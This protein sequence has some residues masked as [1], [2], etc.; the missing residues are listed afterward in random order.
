MKINP[1]GTLGLLILFAQ[2]VTSKAD[3]QWSLVQWTNQGLEQVRVQVDSA[4]DPKWSDVKVDR[5]PIDPSQPQGQVHKVVL[6]GDTGC[7]LKESLQGGSYQDCADLKKWPFR[8]VADQIAAEKPNLVVHLGDYHYREKCSKGELCQKLGAMTGYGFVPWRLDFWEPIAGIL[9]KKT[10]WIIVRGNHE[11]CERAHEGY[12]RFF[13]SGQRTAGQACVETEETQFLRWGTLLVVN[14]DSSAVSDLP[15][16]NPAHQKE[17][18]TRWDQVAKRIQSDRAD[19]VKTVWLVTHKPIL[20]VAPV[21][22]VYLPVNINLRDSFL[23]SRAANEVD[24]IFGGHVHNSHLVVAEKGP[25]QIVSGN[26]GTQLDEFSKPLTQDE[27]QK[28][29]YSQ[30]R[31]VARDFGYV[32]AEFSDAKK[33][34]NFSFRGDQA[35]SSDHTHL[36]CQFSKRGPDCFQAAASMH[37]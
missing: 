23:A 14:V 36:R 10:P 26:G 21:K 18:A 37:L 32:V 24:V 17:W 5:S 20:G 3:A 19:G 15:D 28:L 11:D 25:L 27:V 4:S 7:R 22:G 9:Q 8:Q 6:L 1:I 33:A 13:H 16:L 31:I 12:L 35:T 34:W 2:T 29:G 30:V